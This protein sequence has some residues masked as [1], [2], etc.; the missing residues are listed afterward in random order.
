MTGPVEVRCGDPPT[1]VVT[2][3]RTTVEIDQQRGVPGPPGATGP[4]GPVGP[5]GPQGPVGG[6]DQVAYTHIQDVPATVWVIVHGLP[7][8]PAAIA[9]VDSAGAE[10]VGEVQFVDPTTV[11][12]SFAAPFAGTAYLS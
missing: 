7:F 10:W 9:V 2:E 8:Q 11:R 3:T 5:Q 1:V 12:V 6:V 4:Q